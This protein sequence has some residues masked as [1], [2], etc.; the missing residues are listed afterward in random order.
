MRRLI[1]LLFLIS[2]PSVVV[3]ENYSKYVGEL[4]GPFRE[5]LASEDWLPS[6]SMPEG[7]CNLGINLPKC[8][9]FPELLHCSETGEDS[10]LMKWEASAK[11]LL[12]T[13]AGELNMKITSIIL[14]A[15]K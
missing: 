15:K 1:V 12:V 7:D 14:V 13:T 5:L 9:V 2:W 11:T 8:A 3:A 6:K 4:Y 10:C